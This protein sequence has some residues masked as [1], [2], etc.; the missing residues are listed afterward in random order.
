MHTEVA[1]SLACCLALRHGLQASMVHITASNASTATTSAA[2]TVIVALPLSLTLIERSLASAGGSSSVPAVLPSTVA[3]V[4]VEV[5]S[6][7]S[8]MFLGPD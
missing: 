2:S 6:E 4:P 1:V 8:G 7:V 5:E 3:V